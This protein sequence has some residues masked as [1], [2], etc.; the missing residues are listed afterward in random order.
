LLECHP[1]AIVIFA[2]SAFRHGYTEEDVQELLQERYVRTQSQRG[3]PNVYELFGRNAA[4]DYLHVIYRELSDG[5]WRVFHVTRMTNAHRR[6]YR[7]IQ[8]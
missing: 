7:R 6:R 3:F 8:L 4:G 1:V 5:R 2:E